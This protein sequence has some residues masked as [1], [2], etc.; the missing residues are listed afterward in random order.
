MSLRRRPVSRRRADTVLIAN[1]GADLYGSDRMVLESV[2]A[3]RSAG[4]SVWVTLPADGPLVAELKARGAEVAIC[5][6]PIVRKALASPRGLVTLVSETARSLR[7]SLALLRRVRPDVVYVNTI[8][9][10]LWIV[11]ARL[12][13]RPCVV[14]VHE[15]EASASRG[16]LLALNAPLLFANR[17]IVNS[18]FSLGVLNATLPRLMKKSI[19]V[20]NS[21]AG[22][23]AVTPARETIDGPLRIV[24]VG[25]LSPRKGPDVAV[26]ALGILRSRGV[27]AQLDLVGAVFPGYEW[28]EQQLRARVAELGLDGCVTFSGF[29]PDRWPATAAADVVVVP[30]TVDEPFGNTAVEAILAARPLVVSGIAGL[31]EASDGFAAA[32]RVPAADPNALADALIEVAD[33]WDV[34]TAAAAAD[35]PA[36]VKRYS[37]SAYADAIARIVDQ[38]A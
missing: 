29:Q 23:P 32:I 24:Y 3:L 4:R 9:P 11:L 33:R 37:A 12:L 10:P 31:V 17:L 18:Q 20:Y 25:R 8:T 7:P 38:V 15:A 35:A 5:P 36:A 30:S 14:H 21:I 27:A 2:S 34:Y 28:F 6:T 16:M 1:P 22:P 13:R 26:E 19:V